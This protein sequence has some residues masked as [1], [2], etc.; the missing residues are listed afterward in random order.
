MR[1]LPRGEGK[2]LIYAGGGFGAGTILAHSDGPIVIA[3]AADEEEALEAEARR[4]AT[5]AGRPV[6]VVPLGD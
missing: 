4:L 2:P 3:V 5:F 6:H 1:A